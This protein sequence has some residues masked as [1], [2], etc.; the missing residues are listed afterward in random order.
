MISGRHFPDDW[1]SDLI[2][3]DFRANRVVR[4]KLSDDGAGFSSK[5]MPDVIKTKDK[6][7]RPVDV[8]M[9]PDGALYVA[10]WYNP[11]IN[12][13]EVDFRDPRR[14]KTHGRIWRVT[15]K[16]RPGVERPKIKGQPIGALLELLKS[17]EDYTRRQARLELRRHDR[18]AVWEALDRWALALP[19]DATD[20]V[21]EFARLQALW[22]YQT[23][24]LPSARVLWQCVKAKDPG[25]RAA[26]ARVRG[27]WVG[28][29]P[30]PA[31]A[32]PRL[33]QKV[34]PAESGEITHL[35]LLAAD[36]E[37][38]V[39]LEA[40]RALAN[41][42]TPRAV[43]VAL[44]VLDKPMDR[45]LDFALYLTVNE[46]A[47][48]WLPEFQAGR[49]K[50]DSAKKTEFA[51]KAIRNPAAIKPLVADLKAGKV[52]VESRKEVAELIAGVGGADDLAALF[53]VA[54]A[55][56]TGPPTRAAL[57]DALD[58]A[59]R[60]RNLRPK[61]DAA[62]LAPHL[63]KDADPA[64]FF[65]TVRLAGSWKAK[66]LQERIRAWAAYP[67]VPDATRIAAINSLADL[68]DAESVRAIAAGPGSRAVRVAAVA[69]LVPLDAKAAAKLA[70]PALNA[71]P[72][73]L[74]PNPADADPTPLLAAFIKR[75]DGPTLLGDA[76]RA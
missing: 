64:V 40:V 48:V 46:L 53:E 42:R 44:A 13:G 50:F 36:T 68:G 18:N 6:A 75:K 38:R 4:Y 14:D 58:R 9:G 21:N 25:V 61:A 23:L 72:N 31:G 7:F 33:G 71:D 15:A 45:F 32:P 2:T 27:D 10:D 20:P 29:F 54:L 66:P 30:P 16:G 59:A 62:R 26:A 8:K 39:R 3:C 35:K 28:R 57:L 5:L 12:H 19:D 74:I 51:L 47:D 37:P 67:P 73:S 70:I 56:S 17:P 63:E 22:T 55:P 69:A 1:Q 34:E 11:I 24:D 49:L 65:A 60:Q 52:A 41:V 76:L 43:G